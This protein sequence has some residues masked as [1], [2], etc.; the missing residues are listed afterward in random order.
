MAIEDDPTI[1]APARAEII[2]LKKLYGKL[3]SLL[4]KVES[5]QAE[6]LA[7]E[8]ADFIDDEIKAAKKW[9]E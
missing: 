8:T 9:L 3:L 2:R 5:Y 6:E 1:D 7:H 4:G